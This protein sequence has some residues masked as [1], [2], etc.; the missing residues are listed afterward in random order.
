MKKSPENLQPAYEILQHCA[1]LIEQIHQHPLH[2]S[3][4]SLDHLRIFMEHHVFAVWDFMV[5]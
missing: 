3:M 4:H 1:P 2:H 5:C